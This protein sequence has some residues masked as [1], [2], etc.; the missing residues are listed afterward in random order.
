VMGR[1][2]T[3]PF[4]GRIAYVD[5][6]KVVLEGK[7]ANDKVTFNIESF[8]RTS[9]AT[10]YTQRAMVTEGQQV[11]IG[12]VLIDGPSQLQLNLPFLFQQ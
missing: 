4:E 12:D 3:A 9:A 2:I 11:K 8:D 1:V 7:N 10:S 5:A 6:D